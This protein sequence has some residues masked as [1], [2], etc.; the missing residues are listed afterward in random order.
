MSNQQDPINNVNL[1][2][3]GIPVAVPKGTTILE[4]ARKV[5]VSIPVLCE[6]TGLNRRA[7]CRICVVEADGG[8]K[9]LAACANSVWEGANIITSNEHVFS[10]RKTIIEMILANH[11]QDC[12]SCIRS[13]TC[14]LQTL[15]AS[16]GLFASSFENEAKEGKPVIESET[17]VRDMAKCVKCNRCVE[18]CQEVQTIRAINTSCRSHEYE[19]SAAYK[20]ALVDTPCVFCGGCAAVC[21]VGAIYGHDQTA[22]VLACMVGR[23]TIA[24]VYPA[25]LSFLERE[26]VAACNTIA[27][28]DAAG[29]ITTGKIIAAIRLLGFDKVYDATIAANASGSDINSEVKTRKNSGGTAAKLPIISGCCDGVPRF[30]K[31]FFPD[32][33][34]NLSTAK[35]LR[36]QFASSMKSVYAKEAGLETSNITSVSFVP[37]IAQKYEV[38]LNKTDFALT[39]AELMRMIKMAGIVIAALPEEQFDSFS[40]KLSTKDDSVKKV[41]VNGYGEARK[42]MEAIQKGECDADWVEI[43]SCPKGYCSNMV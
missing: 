42:V 22:E 28:V 12:L 13:K 29:T 2:I 4:A 5:N 16:Y 6:Y 10:A 1:T 41:T 35:N 25:F 24:Q 15:A 7:I 34:A 14:E 30:I 26:F 8:S 19:I 31:S 3:D 32:L 17:L 20:Q 39:A 18:A 21:P 9:L 23:K 40:G 27:C 36:Q 33:A 37:C 38:T 43:L 11:P